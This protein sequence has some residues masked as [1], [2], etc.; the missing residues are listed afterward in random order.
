M[1]GYIL[2]MNQSIM[3]DDATCR[4]YV[5][6]PAGRSRMWEEYICLLKTRRPRVTWIGRPAAYFGLQ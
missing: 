2:Q 1:D 6:W 3:D 4:R 5:M